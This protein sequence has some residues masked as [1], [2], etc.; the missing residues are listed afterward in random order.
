ME[1][2]TTPEIQRTNL[3]DI[4]LLLKS[5]KVDDL[6]D[7]DFMDPPATETLI[8]ALNKLFALGALNHKGELTKKGRQMS[9]LPIDPCIAAS[10][11]ASGNLGCS[12]EIVTIMS[13]IGE[14]SLF[15]RPKDK[16]LHADSA[17]RRFT[18]E[19]GDHLTLLNVFTEWVDSDYSPFWC[20]EN[21]IDPK[22]M[23]RARDVRD[24]LAKLLERIE[25]E[26]ASC[27]ASNPEPIIK[28]LIA[29]FFTN[30]A[31]LE[32]GGQSY[33]TIK[34]GHQT[35]YIHPSSTLMTEDTSLMP[36]TVIYNELMLTTKEWMRGVTKVP[37]VAWLSEAAPHYFKAKDMEGMEEKKMPKERK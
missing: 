35:V 30:A 14:T 15:L 10:I 33:R 24:Q 6:L 1:A 4:V 18:A 37:N 25:V 27:G 28:A 5:L 16:K 7:F 36:K 23:T 3:N 8:D 22:A 34:G 32:K 11:I 9:E 29:G 12:E 20:K 2:E 13:M 17:R 19:S 21:F 26:L 31:R